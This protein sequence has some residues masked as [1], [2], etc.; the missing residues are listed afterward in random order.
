MDPRKSIW[1]V[2]AMVCALGYFSTGIA[3][4]AAGTDA[5]GTDATA[6][7]AATSNKSF[8]QVIKD[9]GVLM[10]PLG[11]LSVA[12]VALAVYGFIIVRE[13]KVLTPE[14][15]PSL[16]EAL[17]GLDIDRA[18]SI[19]DGTPSLLT[20]VVNAGLQRISDGY[21]DLQSM[22]SAMEEAAIEEAADGLK[23]INY[24]SVI[25]QIAPMVGLLGTVSGMIKAFAKIGKGAMGKP[26]VLAGD[27]SEALVTTATGLI[28]GIPAMFLYFYL[29][30]RYT[31]HT[32]RLGRIVGNLAHHLVAATRRGG[33]PAPAGAKPEAAQE[34]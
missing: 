32:T 10:W 5:A 9:G 3:Q 25:A 17:D 24:L 12:T 15:V 21:L 8:M 22:E 27:I 20:N 2:V 13:S 28:I 6:Q 29:K 34:G 33:S 4:E 7:A 30:G 19:C 16:Q 23:T 26:E 31:G 18:K 14:L 1:L 11:L